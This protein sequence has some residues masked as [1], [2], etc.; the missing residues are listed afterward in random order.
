VRAPICLCLVALVLPAPAQG[1]EGLQ[2]ARERW[3]AMT[4]EQRAEMQ[5]R[6]DELRAMG[7]ER[8]GE[9]ERRYESLRAAERAALEEMP[10]SARRELE[11]LPPAQRGEIARELARDELLE[12]GREVRARL[13]EAVRERVERARPA[14]RGEVLRELRRGRRDEGLDTALER[15][16]RELELPAEERERVKGLPPEQREARLFELHRARVAR[17]VE[18]EGV[19]AGVRPDEWEGWS[20]LP[21]REFHQRLDQRRRELGL[22]SLRELFDPEGA[23]TGVG[24]GAAGRERLGALMHPDPR[25]RIELRER[26]R[27]ERRAQIDRRVRARALDFLERNPGTVAPPELARLRGLEGE[28]FLE[29]LAEH[30][31]GGRR[32]D[33]GE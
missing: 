27:E 1:R 6:F 10:E 18:R 8:R 7:A 23:R 32:A 22:R 29:A 20:R 3:E 26:T 21:P 17:R 25:W 31:G 2:A 19:P 9:L 12:R 28:A 33:R 4:P 16:G 11:A 30:R 13:P 5:R 15:L 24:E 14:E